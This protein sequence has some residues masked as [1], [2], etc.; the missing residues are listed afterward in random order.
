M[1]TAV[2]P[3]AG[4]ETG[5]E[6]TLS[7][8]AE[9]YVTEML[10]RGLDVSQQPY[11]AY[12]GQTVAGPSALEQQAFSGLGSMD[13]T[14]GMGTFTPGTVTDTGTVQ[15]Y[16]NPYLQAALD[17]Q[18]EEARRQA[19]ISRTQN[20]ARLTQ[21]GAFGGSRQAIMESEAQR[22][23]LQN[24]AGITG[25]G[26]SQAYD[27][28]VQQFNQE[29]ARQQAAQSLA[30][31]YGFQG[32]GALQGAGATQRGIEQAQLSADRARFEE[33]RDYPYK[34]VQYLQ[35]LLQGLPI[36]S[37]QMTY[38]EPS[39]FGSI[40]GGASGIVSLADIIFGA[41]KE[42]ASSLFDQVGKLFGF[43]VAKQRID[44][45]PPE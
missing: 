38:Q 45:N 24:L 21:A 34:Q 5:V 20:A 37:E 32:L 13:F 18:I 23:L 30:N 8:F 2:D 44:N 16:M 43:D 9:P 19:D 39:T 10:Q 36:K 4:K 33:E 41:E 42:G 11:E 3:M 14:S 17:P 26:Y 31:Q 40:L 28:A 35:S 7:S 1:V 15:Q 29:Q 22:N 12:T 25:Q 27:R 6:S